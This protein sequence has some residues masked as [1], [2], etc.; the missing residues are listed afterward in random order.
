MSDVDGEQQQDD[1]SY[2]PPELRS[3]G[4]VDELTHG[5]TD[6]S[7]VDNGPPA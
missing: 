7:V 5:D 4:S 3:L 1:R 2:E 6:G